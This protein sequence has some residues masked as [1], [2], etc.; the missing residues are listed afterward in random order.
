MSTMPFQNC[1]TEEK[2]NSGA[3]FDAKNTSRQHTD[4]RVGAA[5]EYQSICDLNLE[6]TGKQSTNSQDKI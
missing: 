5:Y 2:N 3:V 4:L 1:L 6:N